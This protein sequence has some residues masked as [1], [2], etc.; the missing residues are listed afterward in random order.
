[1]TCQCFLTSGHVF[2]FTRS[3]HL[4]FGLP[5]FLF[6][7]I[8]ICNISLVAPS[9]SHLYT[10][11]THLNLQPFFPPGYC[12]MHISLVRNFLS[13]FFLTRPHSGPYILTG[14]ITV[15]YTLSLHCRTSL[16]LFTSF[17]ICIKQRA[18]ILERFHCL[19]FFFLNVD[20][21]VFF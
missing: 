7:S 15:L 16:Q 12:N 9:L 3:R 17:S 18:Q 13:C 4:N 6:P 10:C 19:H 8:A 20:S 14:F 1:M 5:R 2:S 21:L 11:P